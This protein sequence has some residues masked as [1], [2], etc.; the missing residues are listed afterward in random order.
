[1]TRLLASAALLGVLLTAPAW[2]QTMTNKAHH[3]Y[4]HA[5]HAIHHAA[6]TDRSGSSEARHH[7]FVTGDDSA[8][9]LNEQV[10]QGLNDRR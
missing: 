10:L 7:R 6:S 8:E 2:A 4:H 5:R 1:M 3:H 9:R